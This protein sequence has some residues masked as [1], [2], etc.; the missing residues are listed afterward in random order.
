MKLLLKLQV[1]S[2]PYPDAQRSWPIW[3][4]RFE[5][6]LVTYD[7][8]AMQFVLGENELTATVALVP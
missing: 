5:S 6:V 8:D 3:S 4:W 7:A 1:P 2:T